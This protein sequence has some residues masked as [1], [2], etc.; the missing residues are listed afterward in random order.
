MSR[1]EDCS[2]HE[3]HADP[4]M[5]LVPGAVYPRAGGMHHLLGIVWMFL[6]ACSFGASAI[7]IKLA[8]S[9]G[10]QPSQLLPLQN[11]AAILCLWP[12]LLVSRERTILNSRQ[13]R[14]LLLQGLVGNFAISVCYFWSA[15][16][17]EVSLLTIIL[18]TYP[19]FVLLHAMLVQ[20]R[21]ILTSEYAALILALLGGALA[22]SPTRGMAAIDSWGLLLAVGAALCYAFM[23]IYGQR[24]TRDLPP[25]VITTYT[26]TISTLALAVVFPPMN[27]FP[28]N[29]SVRQWIY[30]AALGL[31]STVLPMNLLYLGIRRIGALHASIVSV[32]ELPCILVLAYF[33]LHE[34]MSAWQMLGGGMILL[35]LTLMRPSGERDVA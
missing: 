20:K 11:L 32:V 35:G 24:L 16:R 26:S 34:R 5:G 1:T 4:V 29:M 31:L 2:R 28:G 10:L 8:Y 15:N 14:R 22:V 12:L 27:W 9:A 13:I 21:R 19:G 23:N 17:I 7:V 6:A 30:V 3:T 18:F 25:L 33:I